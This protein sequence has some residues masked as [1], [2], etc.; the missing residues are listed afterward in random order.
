MKSFKFKLNKIL[1]VKEIELKQRQRE[2]SEAMHRRDRAENELQEQIAVADRFVSQLKKRHFHSAGE[3]SQHY[4]YYHSLLEEVK[5]REKIVDDCRGAEDAARQKLLAAQKEQ[6]ILQRLK[7]KE[8]ERYW[9][10]LQKEDQELIDELAVL[11][12][13]RQ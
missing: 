13:A 10:A 12:L 3:I 8:L 11:G 9:E 4:E 2:L 6:K 7:D 1:E 5:A